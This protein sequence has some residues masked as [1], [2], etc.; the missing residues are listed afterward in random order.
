M[1]IPW[2]KMY[3][4]LN[5]FRNA[6]SFPIC[7]AIDLC[8][9]AAG[10]F[11]LYAPLCFLLTKHGK[12][13]RKRISNAIV[14]FYPIE[15]LTAAKEQRVKDADDMKLDG[16]PRLPRRRDFVNRDQREVD[17]MFTIIT[18]LD[19]RG[20]IKQLLPYVYNNSDYVPSARLD[21]SDMRV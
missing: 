20:A 5:V 1:H 10:Q 4:V 14:N 18:A 7:S 9:M 8:K 16:M 17:D 6:F 13:H 15:E 3:S 12:L 21:D 2:H 19:E 11:V